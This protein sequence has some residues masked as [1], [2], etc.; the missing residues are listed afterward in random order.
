MKTATQTGPAQTRKRGLKRKLVLSMLLVGVLPLSI[1]LV[2]AFFQ[3]TREIRQVS[4]A[5]FQ[6][7]ATATAKKIDLI[8]MDEISSTSHLATD[9]Q[10]VQA[11]ER[12]RD[13]IAA[14]SPEDLAAMIERE[15]Q[16]WND[17]D[18][19]FVDRILHGPLADMLHQYYGGDYVDPGHPVPVVTR[20]A[21]RALFITDSAGRLV[22]SLNANVGYRHAH[23][24]WWKGAFHKGVGQPYFSQLA[25]DRRFQTY[26]VSLALPIMDQLRYEVIGVLHRVYDAKEFFSPAVDTIRFGKTGHVMLIDSRG[27]VLSCPIL[28]TG[29]KLS[30]PELIRLVTPMK[31]GWVLAPSDGHG[32]TRSSIIGFAPLPNASRI[33]QDSTGTALHMFVWQSSEELFAPIEHL[34]TWITAFGLLAIGML[35]ALGSIAATRIVMP[36]RRLQE[37]ARLIGRGELQSPITLTTGDELEDLAEE[38]N[39]MHRQLSAA[40]AGLESQVEMKTQEVQYLQEST[41]QILDSV[42]DPIVMLDQD[43]RIQYVNR[44]AK[45]TFGLALHDQLDGQSLFTLFQ[46]DESVQRKLRH[47]LEALRANAVGARRQDVAASGTLAL[48]DP[49]APRADAGTEPLRNELHINNRVYRYEWF[50]IKG[51]TGQPDRIGLVFRDTTDESRLQEQL[52]QGEKL[53]SLGVLSAGI[54]HELNNPLV[55]VIGLGEAIQEED[56]PEQMREY[57]KTI[58]QHG[59]RMAAIIRDFTGQGTAL[60]AERLVA[61]D[62][63]EQL[64][65]ALQ[66]A[67]QVHHSEGVTIQTHFQAVPSI[68]ANPLELS[69]AFM[70]VITNAIQAMQ[71]QGTLDLSTAV[72]DHHIEIRIRDTGPGIARNH[73]SKVFDPFFT[74]KRQGEGAGLGLTIARRIIAKYGGQIRIESE[75]GQGTTCTIVFPLPSVSTDTQKGRAS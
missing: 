29:T 47:E 22:A 45:D 33:A 25:F 7:L 43:G 49:L 48:R 5:S 13:D 64:Q 6:A 69:Q 23:K 54:G 17:R 18:P 20:S 60:A 3:G 57:A 51:R 65:Y 75:P 11:L 1:G 34:L 32:G 28:P 74:T 24:A 4:G 55:G 59:R 68:K 56:N 35:I 52:I 62:I 9:L 12:R 73:L 70:N 42:P 37:A 53:A 58:V 21:T 61:V 27:F 15:E 26:T 66:A 31:A 8:V 67:Q 50:T 40:F 41:A 71:G 39:R 16:A 44:A 38:M 10:I 46:A 72:R 30:D 2:M 14:L 19:A 63:N 36:I